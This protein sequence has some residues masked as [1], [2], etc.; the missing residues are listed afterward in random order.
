MFLANKSPQF[1]DSVMT[2]L[3]RIHANF[4]SFS[5]IAKSRVLFQ[6]FA[7]AFLVIPKVLAQNSGYD[8]QDVIVKLQVKQ[9]VD[10]HLKLYL[11]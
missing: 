8:P 11:L 4:Y 7:D 3:Y 1:Y 2:I 9:I 10:G 6:A 5:L